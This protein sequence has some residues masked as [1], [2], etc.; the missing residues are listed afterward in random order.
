MRALPH[1]EEI[2]KE[3]LGMV[4]IKND[5]LV[6]LITDLVPTDFYNSINEI[7]Y[8]KM[9]AMYQRNISIDLNTLVIGLGDHLKDIGGITFLASLI[10]TASSTSQ[11]KAYITI[12]KELSNKRKVIEGCNKAL[13]DIYGEDANSS[14]I[15]NKLESNFINLQSTEREGMTTIEN[16]LQDTVTN[17]ERIFNNGGAMEGITTGYKQI[18]RATGGF[19]RGDLMLIAARPSIGKT[20]L[21]LNMINNIPK[22]DNTAIFEMEMTKD[23][24]CTRLLAAKAILNSKDLAR[25]VDFDKNS[26]LIMQKCNEISIKENLFID[27]RCGL[28]ISQIRAEA[29]KIK[30]KHG[31]DVIV[32]DH[33]GKIQ[34][35]NLKASRNDQLGQVS[36]GLKILAKELNVCVVA[37]SQLSR[38]CEDRSDKNPQLADLR[39]SGNLE[40]DADSILLLFR[41]DY[42]AEREQRDSE[43]PGVL[44]VMIA[45]NRD[46]EVGLIRLNYNTKFQYISEILNN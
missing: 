12:L 45:K 6:D 43:A 3:L 17:Y 14:D 39:D 5:I 16:A 21:V 2:E 26:N 25:A 35:D 31:L 38:K 7:L 30:I 37:L 22:G 40:Q 44:E 41:D 34:P 1:N 18:D 8:S 13:D 4:F 20:A 32:I 24:I 33:I 19:V 36:Q 27:D 10:A 9:I 23:K 29:K 42:Y 15:I 46:G 28:T 11:H